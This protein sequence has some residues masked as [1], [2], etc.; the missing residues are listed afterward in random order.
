MKNILK[1][2]FIS[3]ITLCLSK[4]SYSQETNSCLFKNPLCFYN[5]D[6]L[7]YLQILHKNQQYSKMTNFLYGPTIDGK[8]KNTIEVILA[9]ASF[10]YSLKRVGIKE[11]KQDELVNNLSTHDTRNK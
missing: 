11:K 5:T 8:D 6:I 1:I 4:T 2:F 7:N 10:G 3:L 9:N